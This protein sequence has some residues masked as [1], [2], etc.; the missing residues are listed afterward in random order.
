MWSVAARAVGGCGSAFRVP[1]VDVENVES[2]RGD[3][4]VLRAAV[5]V[6]VPTGDRAA[7]TGLRAGGASGILSACGIGRRRFRTDESVTTL[8]LVMF[9]RSG[10]GC[11]GEG[12]GECW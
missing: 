11:G 9:S 10:I 5:R 7:G 12:G 3:V 8:A 2:G 1:V 6:L 4:G